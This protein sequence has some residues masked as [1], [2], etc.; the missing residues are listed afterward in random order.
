MRITKVYTRTGDKGTTRLVGGREVS[1]A[2]PR[3]DSYGTVDE[4][5]AAIGVVRAFGAQD[6]WNGGWALRLDQVLNRVQHDLF[7]VGAELATLPED[8]WEGMQRVGQQEI[9]ALEASIDA[10]NDDLEPLTEF[11]LPGGGL[12]GAHL[13]LARTICRRAERDVARLASEESDL[14]LAPLQYL[15]RLSDWLFV[16]SRWAAKVYDQPEELW[17]RRDK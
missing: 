1:K 16:A 8:R 5:N 2:S 7:N 14:D 12:V 11:I 9:T 6:D 3:I 4:L 17:R 13:H 15:N 10:L